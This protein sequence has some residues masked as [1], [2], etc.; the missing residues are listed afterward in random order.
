MPRLS[1]LEIPPLPPLERLSPFEAEIVRRR[2]ASSPLIPVPRG[3]ALESEATAYFHAA[4]YPDSPYFPQFDF[5]HMY[6]HGSLSMLPCFRTYQQTRVY[7]C[8]SAVA[9][10]TLY[11]FGV[12]DWEELQIADRMASFHGL[13]PDTH[14][15]IPVKDLVMFF[16]SLGWDV[17]SNLECAARAPENMHVYDPW[18]SERAKTFPTLEDFAAYCRATICAGAPIMVENIDWG[19]HWRVIVGFDDMGTG[20][21][22]HGVL[23]LADPHDTA[24]HCQDGFVI[25][26]I[27]KFYSMWYDI[28]VMERD[29][30]TQPF[31]VARPPW[32]KGG[33]VPCSGM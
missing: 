18:R 21:A 32:L 15:P 17:E 5:Y 26:H 14:R 8:A 20:S 33:T 13:P 6:S 9:L 10:M 11:H 27:D 25:E 19:A 7:S 30:C 12:E 29:E 28:F 3:Y 31:V 4:D 22:A 1:E 24:D 23:I 2:W 16:E